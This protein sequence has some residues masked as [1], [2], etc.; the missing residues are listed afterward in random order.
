MDHLIAGN[1]EG[2]DRKGQGASGNPMVEKLWT[3][4]AHPAPEQIS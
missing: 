1:S 3:N 2:H 4:I